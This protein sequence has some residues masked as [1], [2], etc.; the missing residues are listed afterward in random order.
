MEEAV[1]SGTAR[2]EPDPDRPRGWTLRLD[3]APQSYVDL[4]DPSRLLFEYQRR[5]GHVVD[6]V[7]PPGRPISVLHLGGGA[8]TLPRYVA[9]TRPRSRQQVAEIDTALTALVRR[10]LPLERSAQVR[11]RGADAREVLA[12]APAGGADLVV[13]DVF[14]GARVPAHCTGV[15]FLRLVARA[16]APGGWYAANLTDGSGLRFARAQVATALAVFDEV[17]LIADPAVLRGRRFG[18]LV[19]VAAAPRAETEER[20]EAETDARA[21]AEADVEAQAPGAEPRPLPVAELRRRVASDPYPGRVEYGREAV[22]F[23]AGAAPVTDATA[24]AS[25]EPPA[26]IFTS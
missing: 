23:A 19:L 5:F 14:G 12:K 26:E 9:A 3:G 4:D 1:E 7:A 22:A 2:L 16:L 17:C 8:L 15:E 25:P 21:E 24:V 20:A 11:V 18:N 6:L 10:E 13:A